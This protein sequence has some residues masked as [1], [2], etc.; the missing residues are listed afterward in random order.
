[1]PNIGLPRNVR[2][3]ITRPLKFVFIPK[4]AHP[5]YDVVRAGAEEAVAEFK[6]FGIEIQVVWDAPPAAEMAAH[7]QKIGAAILARPDGLAVACLAPTTDAQVINN[8]V[9]AGLHVLTF[10]T[11]APQSLRTGYVGHSNDYQD[12]ADLGEFLAGKLNNTGK[13]GILTGTLSAP[14]HVGRVNGFKA[15]IAKHKG[16][17]IVF[18]SPDS[19]DLQ[20]AEN[21]T[22]MA[23]KTHP[24][25]QGVFCCN[26]TNPVG[27][28]RAVKKAG[29]AGQIHI[30][31]M[32]ALPET[33][34]Y[35]KE[36]VIDAVKVQRQDEIGYWAVVYLVALNQ[37]R[38]VPKVH[39]IG[40][41]L[42]TKENL[43]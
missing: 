38:T 8:A 1:M 23:L 28:A 31:G 37:G 12:G 10:D 34:Q 3:P 15:A 7:K 39:E 22:A 9:K 32:D 20:Q 13:L 16:L 5:W 27:C 21:L 6:R 4:S 17:Q 40:T 19:D 25:L 42:L 30:V 2:K 24:D 14:N 36:G 11:D 41:T 26:A 29:K 43:A 33:L 35:L 18:A